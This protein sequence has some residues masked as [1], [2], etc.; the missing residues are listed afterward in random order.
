MSNKLLFTRKAQEK[1]L[2]GINLAADATASTL[3]PK[4]Q[5]VLIQ[6]GPFPLISHDGVTVIRRIELEDPFENMGV[7]VLKQ[8][9]EKSNS[10][11]D[12]TTTTTI[13]AREIVNEGLKQIQSGGNGQ[14]LKKDIEEETAVCLAALDT[15][16]KRIKTNAE[17]EQVATISA[18][19]AALGTLVAEAI[20]T[21]GKNGHVAVEEGSGFETTV[22]YKKGLEID[23]GYLSPYF[24]TNEK[25]VEA[26]VE[27]PYILLTDIRLSQNYEIIPFLENFIKVGKRLVI[28]GDVMRESEAL[29]TLVANKLRGTLHVIAIQPPA[30]GGRRLDELE[31]LAALTGATVIK[32]DSGRTLDSVEV[33]ELGRAGKVTAD[34]DK[35][36]IIGGNG[37]GINLDTRI[38]SLQEQMTVSNTPYDK[39]IKKQRIAKLAGGVAVINVGAFSDIALKEK[40]DRVIDAVAATQAAVEDGIVAGGEIT[41][42]ELS[43]HCMPGSILA[44]AL[45]APFKQL[46]TNAGID[47]ATARVHL[48]SSVYPKGIDVMDGKVKDL[49]K[50]GVIDPVKVTKAAIENAVSVATMIMTVSCM[51]VDEKEAS[52]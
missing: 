10:V 27:D 18:A 1:L 49:I 17:I 19:D 12:G 33:T 2:R 21:V 9:A 7:Q 41:L 20:I 25:R 31:D 50:A 35:T 3:G 23:R 39:E 38:A 36:V 5:N 42:L 13:I 47:Y 8:A 32:A 30:W 28:I 48:A 34:R 51:I 26:E 11:G 52:H 15:L 24:V 6:N 40:R 37:V 43:E 45:T 46:V 4:G 14:T 16:K 22:E 44:K 29:A